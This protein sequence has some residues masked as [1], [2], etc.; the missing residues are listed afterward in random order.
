MPLGL[1][2]P[3]ISGSGSRE[4]SG[5]VMK[6]IVGLAFAISAGYG[7]SSEPDGLYFAEGS[8]GAKSADAEQF[9]NAWYSKHLR[10]MAEPVLVPRS[11]QKNY[12]FLWLRTFHHPV[13]VRVTNSDGMSQLIA[14]ELDGAGGYEP[15]K[16]ARRISRELTGAEMSS[17]EQELDEQNFWRLPSQEEVFGLDGSRW[18]IEACA[19]ECHVIDR[20]TPNEGPARVLG[21]RFLAL[22]GWD[23]RGGD[24][25]Y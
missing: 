15:G 19:K 13:A 12:R 10:A 25:Y 24:G 22:A 21:E 16:E 3:I 4:V 6:T 18:I 17:L 5:I 2:R 23:F 9:R 14:V 11:G 1:F 8:L 20:W 7:I